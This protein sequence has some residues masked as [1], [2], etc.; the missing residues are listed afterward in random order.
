MA[1]PRVAVALALTA[2]PAASR[3]ATAPSEPLEARRVVFE[4][5]LSA[6]GRDEPL[7]VAVRGGPS[8]DL[9]QRVARVLPEP[10]LIFVSV[11]EQGSLVEQM[12]LVMAR[13]DLSCAM[14]LEARD[15]DRWNLQFWG[16]CA[17]DSALLISGPLGTGARVGRAVRDPSLDPDQQAR[18]LGLELRDG[19]RDDPGAWRVWEGSGYQLDS[20]RF[21]LQVGDLPTVRQLER[22]RRGSTGTAILLAS[23]GGAAAVTGLTVMGSG[24]VQADRALDYEDR[25]RAEQQAWTGVVIGAAG[26]MILGGVPRLRKSVA[27]RRAHPHQVYRRARAQELV[28]RYNR[29]LRRELVPEG[30]DLGPATSEESP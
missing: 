2:W 8:F 5:S 23:A 16:D 26:A 6:M 25:V 10:A 9:Q 11:P 20:M 13:R 4:L 27:Q 29:E 22:E 28:D 7:L 30:P 24:F 18:Q 15:E 14:S 17:P 12:A 1:L 19:P 3:A 21:A